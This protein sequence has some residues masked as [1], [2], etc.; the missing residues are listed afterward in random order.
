MGMRWAHEGPSQQASP[1]T[2]STPAHNLLRPQC[3]PAVTFT[4]PTSRSAGACSP[5][6]TGR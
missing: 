5:N 3:T 2:L 4:A 6:S 1:K